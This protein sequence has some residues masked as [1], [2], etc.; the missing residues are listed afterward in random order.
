[1]ESV[2]KVSC[3]IAA[4]NV[5]RWIAESIESALAQ[6]WPADRLEIVV[7]NDGSTDGTGAAIAPYRDRIRYVEKANGGLVSATNAGLE[8]ATGDL[9]AF[10]DGDDTW[11]VDRLRRQVPVLMGRPE[12]G[13]LHGDM[14]IVDEHGAVLHPSFF[15]HKEMNPPRGRVLGRLMHGNFVSA[16]GILLRASLRDRFYPISE[17]CP[18]QD[19]YIAARVAEVAEIDHVD[20][21][22]YNYRFHGGN[23]SLGATGDKFFEA[24]RRDVPWLLWLQ[25]N[26]DTTRVPVAELGQA[27]EILMANARGVAGHL[28]TTATALLPPVGDAERAQSAREAERAAAALDAGEVEAAARAWARALAIDPWNGAAR[29]NLAAALVTASRAPQAPMAERLDARAFPILAFADELVATPEMIDAY[30]RVFG[31][32]DPATLVIQAAPASAESLV[33]ELAAMIESAGLDGEDAADLLVH[34]CTEPAELLRAGVRAVY[35]RRS[36]PERYAAVPAVAEDHLAELRD[37]IAA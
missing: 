37:R 15:A 16:G 24:I 22:V 4:Y 29:A 5:E 7:V 36:L 9:I 33:A 10:L 32:A 2:P 18:Y 34:P 30:G 35:T 1:V 21:S 13:L 8:I 11:P 31:G 17:S 28:G 25:R 14:T 3:L 26:V 20:W 12:L 19:W 6:D 23:E 27:H